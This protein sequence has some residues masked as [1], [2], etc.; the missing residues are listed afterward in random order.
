[1]IKLKIQGGIIMLIRDQKDLDPSTP[2]LVIKPD[3]SIITMEDENHATFFQNIIG[4]EFRK[5][6]L[7]ARS[8]I[9][10]DN[11]AILMQI[12]LQQLNILPYQGCESGT[13]QY[14]GGTLYINDLDKLSINQLISIIDVYTVINDSYDMVIIE[15]ATD[16][17]DDRFVNIDEIANKLK[18]MDKG[19]IKK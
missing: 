17:K 1:M 18:E 4:P 14:S 13:R 2:G 12:L 5:I 8:L 15:T 3:G 6:G 7:N 9:G 19:S 10:Q 11:L 16:D